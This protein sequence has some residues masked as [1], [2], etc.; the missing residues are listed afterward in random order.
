ME[1]VTLCYTPGVTDE[2]REGLLKKYEAKLQ[3]LDKALEGKSNFVGDY[4]TVADLYFYH[5]ASTLMAVH[6]ESVDK[7]QNLVKLY[8]AI[9]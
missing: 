3:S 8:W 6:K 7:Y 1:A 2:Q 9:D 4:T 5:A